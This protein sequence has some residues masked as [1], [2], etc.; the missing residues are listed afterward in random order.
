MIL[1]SAMTQAISHR[2][3]TSV[4]QLEDVSMRHMISAFAFLL[5]STA[6]FA[7]D[8]PGSAAVTTGSDDVDATVDLTAGSVAAGIGY[9]WGGGDLIYQ[10]Q[11]HQFK[12]SGLS[13]VDVGA[14]HITA[15]GVV[16]HMKN[17]SDF[18][19]NYTAVTAGLTVGGGASAALLKN[20]HGVLIKLIST[21]TGL[22][23]N[24]AAA[25][26]SLKLTD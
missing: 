22:R 13:V 8:A 6:A 20:E 15:S 21:T 23:F 11:K 17:I 14:A 2:M 24:L 9:V 5:L 4:T 18:S 16:Y 26:I 25:G 1:W 12:V 19:G 3:S 7:A 10:G